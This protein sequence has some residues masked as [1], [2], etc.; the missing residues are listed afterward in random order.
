M[1]L[2]GTKTLETDRLILRK[3]KDSDVEPMFYNWANDSRVTKY[4]TWEPYESPEQLK[5]TYHHS[6]CDSVCY[7]LWFGLSLFIS[8]QPIYQYGG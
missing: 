2:L 1:K 5:E 6:I 8:A 7:S 3:T 4:L